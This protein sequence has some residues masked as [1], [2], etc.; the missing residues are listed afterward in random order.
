MN[1]LLLK[2]EEQGKDY[3][4]EFVLYLHSVTSDVMGGASR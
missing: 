3:L 4:L 2:A 1:P